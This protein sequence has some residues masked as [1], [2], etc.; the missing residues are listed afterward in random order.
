M[1]ELW[2]KKSLLLFHIPR[3]KI[4]ILSIGSE[5]SKGNEVTRMALN[6][7]RRVPFNFDL[8]GNVE[9]GDIFRGNVDVVVTDGFVGN[10]TLKVGEGVG[11][12][13][14][15]L[16]RSEVHKSLLSKIGF[17][18]MSSVFKKLKKKIDYTEYG[19]APLLGLNKIC[20]I[21]HGISGNKA[22]KNAIRVA[23]ESI[24][25]KVNSQISQ[26][27]LAIKEIME[28]EVVLGELC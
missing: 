6:L 8:V 16:I 25:R 17:F 14:T 26:D 10:V 12:M 18:L 5:D 27:I 19:G 28:R 23:A 2:S 11:E 21:C 7:I 1:S 20:I 3:P 15:A 24:T 4:G 13:I 22:I 9:G